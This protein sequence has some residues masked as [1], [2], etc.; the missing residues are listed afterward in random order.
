M[1]VT[2]TLSILVHANTQY[3][4]MLVHANT[5]YL[6]IVQYVLVPWGYTNYVS[7]PSN[8][9]EL[10]SFL[11][12]SLICLLFYLTLFPMPYPPFVLFCSCLYII[13]LTVYLYN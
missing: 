11:C 6:S 2:L 5:Q 10:V 4:S 1:L 3:L 12:G 7:R 8:Q 9:V 13:I